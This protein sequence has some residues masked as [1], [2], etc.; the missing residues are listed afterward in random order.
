[1]SAYCSVGRSSTS[2][3][4]TRESYSAGS[5]SRIRYESCAH[6]HFCMMSF[7]SVR[8]HA[9]LLIH[10]L[11]LDTRFYCAGSVSRRRNE[12]GMCTMVVSPSAVLC[13]DAHGLRTIGS[14]TMQD[15]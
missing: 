6:G 15:P 14:K 9:A 12:S 2:M 13:P 5:V 11:R 3:A 7:V 4:F 1:M 10:L 8:V